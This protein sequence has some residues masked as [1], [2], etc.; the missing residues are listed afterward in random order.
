MSIFTKNKCCH[1]C[2]KTGHQYDMCRDP[3]TSIGIIGVHFDDSKYG[4]M[5]LKNTT[6]K[7]SNTG[8]KSLM[9]QGIEQP[10]SSWANAMSF[11]MV[12]RRCSLG[13]LEFMRGRYQVSNYRQIISLFQQMTHNEIESISENSFFEIWSKLWG[14]TGTKEPT[15]SEYK[16]SKDKFESLRLK[17]GDSTLSLSFFTKTIKPM[18]EWSEWGFPKGRRHSNESNMNCACREFEEETGYNN[19]QYTLL[20]FDPIKEEFVGTNG[21][22]YCHIYQMAVVHEKNESQCTNDTGEIGSVEWFRYLDAL[23]VIREYHTAKKQV[24]DIVFRKIV[25]NLVIQEHISV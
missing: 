5:L 14:K 9:E 20:D 8:I 18:Y 1:N 19:S 16:V 7:Q 2:G 22:P 12:Q 6:I 13:F 4:D 17:T 21:I 25:S 24:L 15:N 23:S 11:I 3:I 10:N